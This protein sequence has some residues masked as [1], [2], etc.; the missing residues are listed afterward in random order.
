MK[1]RTGLGVALIVCAA[2]EAAEPAAVAPPAQSAPQASISPATS[3]APVAAIAKPTATKP[4]DLR[5]GKVRQY[6]PPE[7]YQAALAAP[8]SDR[9]TVVV[10]GRSELLPVKYERPIPVAPIA[11]FWAIF[12]PLQSWKIL[13]PDL[14]RPDPGPPDVV[15][16]P[17][18]RWGP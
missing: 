13:V 7:E 12:H 4:L 16:P 8:D 5:I 2:A 6:M 11:P 14:N 9:N 18:F 17:V 10:E 15:P 3:S 1:P